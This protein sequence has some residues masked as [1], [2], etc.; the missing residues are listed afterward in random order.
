MRPSR[1]L[2][3]VAGVSDSA[4]PARK[5]GA[6]PKVV[7][8]NPD[9]IVLNLSLDDSSDEAEKAQALAAVMDHAV[10]MT[11]AVVLARPMQSWP[12]RPI[13]LASLAVVTLFFTALT[14]I[15]YPDWVFGASPALMSDARREAGVR[16]AMYLSAGRLLAYRDARGNLP[17]TL[18]AVGDDWD[19][20]IYTNEGDGTF[21]LQSRLGNQTV[22]LRSEGDAKKFLGLSRH[23]LRERP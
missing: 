14:F 1:A 21:V 11:R 19:G 10:R 23:Y 4:R 6:V 9:D 16:M 15:A 22:V 2:P 18:G 7:P 13:V 5:S 12:W 3:S 8:E 17:E 20:V